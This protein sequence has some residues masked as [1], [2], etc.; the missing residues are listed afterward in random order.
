MTRE[1]GSVQ[2]EEGKEEWRWTEEGKG[3]RAKEGGGEK[4]AHQSEAERTRWSK[5]V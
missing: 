1:V 2:R 5:E 4:Q 3:K